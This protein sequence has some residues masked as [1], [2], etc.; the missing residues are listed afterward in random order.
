MDLLKDNIKKLFY[1]FLFPSIGG[2]LVVAIYSFVDTIAV[3]HGVGPNGTAAVAVVTPLVA[4]SGFLSALFG[5]GGS[6]L[7]SKAHGEGNREKANAYFTVS[8]LLVSVIT[9]LFWIGLFLFEEPVLRL[10]G[11]DDELLP[12]AADYAKW[13]LIMFPSFVFSFYI[14]CFIRNDGAPNLV[15]TAS[16]AGGL[17]NVFG[18][19][20]FV[21]PLQWGMEG[22][23]LATGLGSLI[24]SLILLGYLFT[25]RCSLKLAKPFRWAP[26][27]RK[28]FSCGMGASISEIALTISGVVLN[29]Q[30]M[31]YAGAN[32]LAVFGV[33]LTLQSLFQHIFSGVG[34]AA[35]PL[36]SANSKPGGKSA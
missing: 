9:I 34:Q 22:A 17:F 19:W 14:S 16:I 31:R 32:A 1:R 8:L 3:G 30:I 20:L 25:K 18:D 7:L 6:V 27:I 28:I 35:Q 23:S 24:Q 26:A 13:I 21:F 33:I 29:I 36:V 12:Y 4:L 10:L 15:V 2:A 11:A 5:T